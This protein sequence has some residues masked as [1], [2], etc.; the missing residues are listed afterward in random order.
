MHDRRS[1]SRGLASVIAAAACIASLL[2]GCSR[3]PQDPGASTTVD[4]RPTPAETTVTNPTT[5][6]VTLRFV[7][8]AVEVVAA[9]P[10]HGNDSHHDVARDAEEAVAGRM[11]LLRYRVLDA[12]GA[13][14]ATGLIAA[15]RV[16]IAEYPDPAENQRIVREE[17]PLASV[18][19]AV[20]IP[21]NPAMRMLEL[22]ELQP[23]PSTPP[24]SWPALPARRL[25][26]R[27]QVTP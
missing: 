12:N 25:D 17:E 8:D 10:K 16:A 5:V 11:R 20:S 26:L 27:A 1:G 19:A 3:E 14:L 21:Y 4:I 6:S 22:T 13:M 23:Q 15:P 18:S 2:A 7:G 9:E 24:E